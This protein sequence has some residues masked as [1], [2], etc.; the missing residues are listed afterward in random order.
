MWARSPVGGCL[1]ARHGVDPG[2]VGVAE[3]RAT[4]PRKHGRLHAMRLDPA[5][6]ASVAYVVVAACRPAAVPQPPGLE[7]TA[8]Q[9]TT[10][11]LFGFTAMNPLSPV[12]G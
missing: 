12:P 3:A 7:P 8:P 10:S 6:L 9:N 1:G 5:P 4:G 11:G 2:V